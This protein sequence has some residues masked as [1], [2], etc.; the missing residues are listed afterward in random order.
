MLHRY[1]SDAAA[2]RAPTRGPTISD[3]KQFLARIDCVRRRS[4]SR[5]RMRSLA[6]L[7]QFAR[8]PD[9]RVAVF[10]LLGAPE[11]VAVSGLARVADGAACAASRVA[12]MVRARAAAPVAVVIRPRVAQARV[13]AAADAVS[14]GPA[15]AAVAVRIESSRNWR[16]VNMNWFLSSARKGSPWS[17]G[18]RPSRRDQ[19]T[20]PVYHNDAVPGRLLNIEN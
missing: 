5:S 16:R 9:R 8:M 13:A 2:Q 1:A 14:A 7:R 18:G 19:A 10:Q 4:E 15:S 12:V 20:S 17:C 3:S 6:E 11:A